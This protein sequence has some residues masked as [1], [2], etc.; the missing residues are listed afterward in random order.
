MSTK[1]TEPDIS[2]Q[3]ENS[4]K[5]VVANDTNREL[6]DQIGFHKP[7]AGFYY[8]I[9]LALIGIVLSI[10]LFGYLIGFFYPY[11]ESL[12]YKDIAFG[13]FSL[14]F[15]VF[16]TGTGAVMGRFIPEANIKNPE[17]MIHY[18]Q[19][20]IWYQMLTGLIQTTVVSVY[21]LF[22]ASQASMAYTV[23]IMLVCS[24]TQWPGFLWV[25][26]NVIDA[27]QYYDKSRIL[28][29]MLGTVFQNFTNYLFLYLGR[30][31]GAAHPEMG[32]ILGIAIGAAVGSYVDDF[33]AMWLSAY[34][35]DKILKNYGVT[36]KRCFKV[37]FTWNEIKPV[38]IY[39]IKT[40][41]PGYITSSVSYMAFLITVNYIP[42]YTTLMFLATIGGSIADTLGWFGGVG[43]SALISESYLNGKP[44]LTQYYIGQEVR[45]NFFTLGF[46]IPIV[47][48]L[49]KVMPFAW[50]ALHMAQYAIAVNFMIP[51]LIRFSIERFRDTPGN[52]MY[53]ADKPN[54][55]I[56]LGILSCFCDLGL[57]YLYLVVLELPYK[58]GFIGTI[59]LI[60]IGYVPLT[61]FI[62]ILGYAY[63]HRKIVKIKVPWKQIF[64][65]MVIPCIFS[66]IFFFVIY[67]TVLLPLGIKY[68]FLLGFLPLGIPSIFAM[69]VFYFIMSGFLGGWDTINLDEFCK[70]SQMS[71]PS[72][73]IIAPIYKLVE[74]ACKKSKYHNR[75]ALPTEDVVRNAQE[76]L[77]I[78]RE[79]RELLKQKVSHNTS[80]NVIS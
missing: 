24:T 38:L 34:F 42:Q 46:W 39:S 33:A 43:G 49:A 19:Y 28:N 74:I 75:F 53:G 67:V 51:T 65:G 15:T 11:P 32:E 60:T 21:A 41:V 37:E 23:W 79:N 31:Y 48:I 58:I 77:A 73:F 18:I 6:W 70:A 16:D 50:T 66:Y 13:Y 44:A 35:F 20:F 68:G 27:L 59:W 45:F 2:N 72:R 76:L 26:K 12:G 56:F 69:L 61:I 52:V 1:D 9:S 25:F 40:G 57:K 17:K 7:I 8:N 62:E 71:G 29:F 22:Y 5:E 3:K 14:L 4:S 30:L 10:V 54:F 78:K 80:K 55:G 64:I 36:S 47:L 63:V